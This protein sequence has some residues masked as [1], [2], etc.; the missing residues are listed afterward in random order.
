V[1]Y[2]A[3]L[4]SNAGNMK[5]TIN[6][7]IKF[8]E[9]LGK[10]L[11]LL[12]FTFLPLVLNIIIAIIPAENKITALTEKIIPGEM[13][14]YCLSFIAPLF[15]FFLTTHGTSFKLPALK[16]VF[17][18][19][20]IIYLLALILTLIAK[21]SLI[22]GIDFKPGHRD[23]YFW[24]ALCSLI[25]ALLLRL[26]AAYQDSRFSDYKSESDKQQEKFNKDFKS[27]L[28]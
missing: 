22:S 10:V 8:W 24:L 26:Y 3:K 6:F 23:L 11:L 27:S 21:N 20:F 28:G 1:E 12:T 15:I 17:I 16:F 19:S 18:A 25:C 5:F 7:K 14:A 13:L 2:I 4:L 9:S